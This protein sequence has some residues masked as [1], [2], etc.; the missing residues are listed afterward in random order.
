MKFSRSLVGGVAV[1]AIAASAPSAMAVGNN[2]CTNPN[3]AIPFPAAATNAN[4]D[5]ISCSVGQVSGAGA[6][7]FVDFFLTPSSTNDWIDA[8]GDGCSGFNDMSP[9]TCPVTEGI[10]DQLSEPY[11]DGT[12]INSPFLFNY[13]SVG[14]V[15]GFD[16][17]VDG[18]ICG[19]V[20]FNRAS[21]AGVFNR[22][23]YSNATSVLFTGTPDNPS[24]TPLTQCEIEFS[25]LDVFAS[26]GVIIPDVLAANWFVDP[27]RTGYGDCPIPNTDGGLSKLQPLS[28]DCYLCTDGVTPCVTDRNCLPPDTCDTGTVITSGT[29]NQNVTSPLANADTIYSEVGAW[30]AV[31]IIANRGADKERVTYNQMQH[32][33]VTGRF[34][35]GENLVAVTRDV[36]SGT[37]NAIMNS[38]GID[39]SWGRGDNVGDRVD[40]ENDVRLGPGTQP[41]NCGGS[42]ISERAVRGR[43]LA[44][45]Y[46]GLSGSSRTQGDV[47]AGQYEMLDVCQDVESLGI[48][49]LPT[50]ELCSPTLPCPGGAAC[51]GY[52]PPCLCDDPTDFIRAGTDTVLNNCDPCTSFRSAG[53]GSFVF[54]GNRNRNRDPLDPN[55]DPDALQPALDNDAV[56]LYAN[57]IF[58][59]IQSFGVSPLF[60]GQCQVSA[61]CSVTTATRCNADTDCP[62]GETCNKVGCDNDGQCP[63]DRCSVT[64]TQSCVVDGDCPPGETCTGGNDDCDSKFNMPGEY[65]AQE[66]FLRD[67]MDCLHQFDGSMTYLPNPNLVQD[68]QDYI[69][70][71]SII[72][73][74]AYGTINA[75]T[76]AEVPDRLALPV[77][78]VTYYSDGQTDAYYQY[79]GGAA[80]VAGS[81]PTIASGRLSQRNRVQGD[82]NGDVTRD[83]SDATELVKAYYNPRA[84]QASAIAQGTGVLG[85]QVKDVAIPEVIGDFQGDGNLSKEDL[86]YFADGL[87]TVRKYCS[88]RNAGALVPCTVDANCLPS[89]GVCEKWADRKA[90]A[91]AIDN[92]ILDC[93][94]GAISKVCRVSGLRCTTNADCTGG[95][96]PCECPKLPWTLTNVD[97]L[98]PEIPTHTG[99]LPGPAFPQTFDGV[100]ELPFLVTGKPYVAGDFRADV[101]G[102]PG[103]IFGRAANAGGPPVGWDG[104][105]DEADI[106]YC[107]EKIRAGNW[108]DGVCPFCDFSCDMDGDGDT[109]VSDVTGADGILGILDTLAGDIDLNGVVDL[110]DASAHAAAVCVPPCGWTGGDFDCDGNKDAFPIGN[111]SAGTAGCTI[112]LPPPAPLPCTGYPN[113]A[114]KNRFFCFEPDTGAFQPGVALGYR[115]THNG[116]GT[117]Y[118][119][120]KPRTASPWTG[121]GVSGL[122]SLPIV[123][124]AFGASGNPV[125]VADCWVAPGESYTVE[126]TFDGVTFSAPLVVD[127]TPKPTNSRF[128]ADIA[129][130]FAAG[131]DAG[132]TPPTPVNSWRPQDNIVSGFDIS[133]ALQG[134][135]NAPTAPSAFWGDVNPQAVDGVA[136]GPDTLRIVNAFSVGTGREFYPFN[137][138]DGAGCTICG[139][140]PATVCP[141]PAAT[142]QP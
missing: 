1:V 141:V 100:D 52:Q 8:D 77:S 106:D 30:V 32:H 140:A 104:K 99:P 108:I 53:S 7:L 113:Q 126:S 15:R 20:P 97:T 125:N 142:E 23:Q 24:G 86:R 28:R 35:S 121:R 9:P 6:T 94:P 65:L 2:I 58:D 71:N 105:V 93:D 92:A 79:N 135:A 31:A 98:V 36:G 73:I 80:N 69:S 96:G 131:G 68:L 81:F 111:C 34:P 103:S 48:C 61:R 129:G 22:L 83:I 46:T 60:T 51:L 112:A 50:R 116:S 76:G 82:F 67:A 39:T 128:W 124:Y 43:R 44:I 114:R 136:N 118:Y 12:D 27:T 138:P 16:E 33:F 19:A 17:F 90:A 84:W 74:P 18:Q 13:R 115:V 107:C 47:P 102:R 66:F 63:F 134:A 40:S 85:S 45:G 56:A 41:T 89:F 49:D 10:V 59:S 62:V 5:L 132:S 123:T 137:H 75:N 21:E 54:R 95:T 101:A 26:W 57:N 42:G 25:F 3:Y 110:N 91:I 130:S 117:S 4:G 72:S 14:S 139:A 78:G 87:G 29:L 109:D 70:L 38:L 120:G 64:T 133:A 11:S 55:Y 119:V 88:I 37:R 127:A 122:S